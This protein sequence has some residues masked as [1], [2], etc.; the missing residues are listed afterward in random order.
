M[1]FTSISS[2]TLKVRVPVSASFLNPLI[3]QGG[4]WEI[5]LVIRQGLKQ[6][7]GLAPLLWR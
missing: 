7:H 1:G 3:S 2:E 6:G 5:R 4:E